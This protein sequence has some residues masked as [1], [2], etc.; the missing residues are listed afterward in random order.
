MEFLSLLFLSAFLLL[1]SQS[2]SCKC[3]LSAAPHPVLQTGR[4]LTQ[5][6]KTFNFLPLFSGT[7]METESLLLLDFH[8]VHFI[9]TPFRAS[10]VRFELSFSS[11]SF[12]FSLLPLLP[13]LFSS[14]GRGARG[15]A[16]QAL[17]VFRAGGAGA[18]A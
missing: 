5:T 9:G 14:R 13:R 15:H 12:S 3:I 4:K 18:R 7:G 11:F 8:V 10:V 17:R 2:F 1:L 16:Q 6:E